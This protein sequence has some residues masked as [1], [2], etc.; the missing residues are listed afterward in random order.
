MKRLVVTIITMLIAIL[1]LSVLLYAGDEKSVKKEVPKNPQVQTQKPC[2]DKHSQDM[3]KGQD[4]KKCDQ[5]KCL[6]AC[7]EKHDKGECEDHDPTK[8]SA[9]CLEKCTGHDKPPKK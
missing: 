4:L 1:M 6:T 5:E 8:C 2:Q 9:E 7:K 3:C